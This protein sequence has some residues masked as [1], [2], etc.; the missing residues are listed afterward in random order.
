MV[1][2]NPS[3]LG[4][5]AHNLPFVLAA[6][7]LYEIAAGVPLLEDARHVQAVCHT[8]LRSV[9]HRHPRAFCSAGSVREFA[10]AASSMA[11][12]DSGA[13]MVLPITTPNRKGTARVFHASMWNDYGYAW[14]RS[15][16]DAGE[17]RTLEMTMY[18]VK[19]S[20]LP[21]GF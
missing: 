21:R 5:P 10:L 17:S 13:S 9:D 2:I 6:P 16:A 11:N 14:G 12:D 18:D 3:D 7:S 1:L 15:E 4:Y 8:D 19:H 20:V